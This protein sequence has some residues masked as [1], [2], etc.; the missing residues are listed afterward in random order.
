VIRK[1]RFRQH[2]K[3]NNNICFIRNNVSVS[4]PV[5]VQTRK[6][7]SVSYTYPWKYLSADT[8]Q[9][10]SACHIIPIR[11]TGID[12]GT[13]ANQEHLKPLA[14]TLQIDNS[15]DFNKSFRIRTS[16]IV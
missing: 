2:Q 10:I 9:R 15:R 5:S 7:L 3:H 6:L 16:H 12:Y 1:F 8:Y 4:I 14:V 11:I 13:M